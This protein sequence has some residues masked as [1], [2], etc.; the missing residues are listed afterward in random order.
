MVTPGP[1]L[2]PSVCHPG[3]LTS[4]AASPDLSASL[5]LWEADREQEASDLQLHASLQP[6]S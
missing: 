1:L 5:P 2:P 4:F 6:A 3:D